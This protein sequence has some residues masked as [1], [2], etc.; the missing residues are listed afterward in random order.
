MLRFEFVEMAQREWERKNRE[1]EA[2]GVYSSEGGIIFTA[3]DYEDCEEWIKENEE[4][5]EEDEEITIK[6]YLEEFEEWEEVF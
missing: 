6:Q 1:P 4:F 5:F 3:Y 2:Y